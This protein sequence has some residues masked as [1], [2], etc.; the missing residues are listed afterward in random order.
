MVIYAADD[1]K[2]ALYYLT[3]AIE[4]CLPDAE[5]CSFLK[6][7]ELI[8]AIR[9][10]RPD[11]IFL[12]VEMPGMNGIELA[13][14]INQ[15][16][17]KVNII[18][19]TGYENYALK[20][21]EVYASAYLLKP[22]DTEE[23]KNA[24]G[25]LRYPVTEE[26]KITARTF[27]NFDLFINGRPITF[28][29]DKEKELIAF[30]IDRNGATV[31]RKEAAGILYEDSDYTRYIQKELCR[32]ARYLAEDLAG[33][34]IQENEIFYSDNGYRVDMNRIECDLK[35]Y[36]EGKDRQTWSGEYME[37]YSWGEYRKGALEN[38]R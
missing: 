35:E 29:S 28:R 6:Q 22:V 9:R 11:I 30:L 20:A 17:P 15:L 8:D 31:T 37:Q 23:L 7:Y 25:R 4:E 3:E 26:R 10:K 19:V 13:R 5:I 21:F 32:I 34:G 12:D 27:G 24:L 16:A 33:A 14:Q 36:M 18:F 2:A 38:L 1:E